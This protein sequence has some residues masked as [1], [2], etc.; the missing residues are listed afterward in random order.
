MGLAI[1]LVGEPPVRGN[2]GRDPVHDDAQVRAAIGRITQR[3]TTRFDVT[4]MA[5]PTPQTS[6]L[7][8]PVVLTQWARSADP[9]R[10]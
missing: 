7:L 4:K 5:H 3:P 2:S 10:D 8:G 9:L 6:G 1:V